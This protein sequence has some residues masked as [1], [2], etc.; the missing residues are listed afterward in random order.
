MADAGA[1]GPVIDITPEE[2]IANEISQSSIPAA[3]SM[4]N[5]PWLLYAVIAVGL[6]LMWEE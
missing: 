5:Q 3:F 1:T 6:F 4:G 2:Q